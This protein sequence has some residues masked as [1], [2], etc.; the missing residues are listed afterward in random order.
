MKV[1]P[2]IVTLFVSAVRLSGFSG[3]AR[4]AVRS[5]VRLE[6][7]PPGVDKIVELGTGE[8]IPNRGS[9]PGIE[10][11]CVPSGQRVERLLSGPLR[12]SMPRPLGNVLTRRC[13][14]SGKSCTS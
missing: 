3:S 7:N 1:R 4:L 6:V 14:P 8:N 11:D 13:E 2:L 10:V 5:T 9:G 12:L